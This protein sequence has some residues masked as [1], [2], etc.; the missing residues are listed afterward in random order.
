MSLCQTGSLTK[1]EEE[2]YQEFLKE[3]ERKF[4]VKID[5]TRSMPVQ[6][7]KLANKVAFSANDWVPFD[8][9][10]VPIP[11]GYDEILTNIYGDYMEILPNTQS[12]DYSFFKA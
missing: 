9:I 12:R 3:I 8:N 7:T 10:F 6:P 4:M 5:R 11:T 1:E 2:N